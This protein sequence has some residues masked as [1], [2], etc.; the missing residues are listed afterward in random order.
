MSGQV[1]GLREE[2]FGLG[3]LRQRLQEMDWELRFSFL[4]QPE[5]LSCQ[6]LTYVSLSVFG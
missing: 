1:S 3:F 5:Y 6:C 4:F 2:E